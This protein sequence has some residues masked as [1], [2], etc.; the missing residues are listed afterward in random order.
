M[1]SSK[2]QKS[3]LG[4]NQEWS[5]YKSSRVVI[6]PAPYEHTS[7]FGRGTA[8][9]PDQILRAS[10]YLEL[11]D[12]ELDTEIYRLT[13]GI[14]TLPSLSVHDDCRD[15]CVVE[16]IRYEVSRHISQ[17][18]MVVTIGGE[19]TIAIGCATAYTAKFPGLNVLQLDAHS[20]L[21]EEYE[22]NRYSHA[23]VMARICEFNPKIVQLGIRSQSSEEA[24]FIRDKD[25]TT[26]YACKLKTT[27]GGSSLLPWADDVI[28]SL[29][30]HVYITVDCDFFDPSVL[31]AVGTPEPGGFG[32][33][34]TL[35]FLRQLAAERTIVGFDVNELSPIPNLA[36]PE[37]TAAKL[38][39]K[40]IGYIFSSTN[41]ST[42]RSSPSGLRLP[43]RRD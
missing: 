38:I 12:D 40:L 21:R 6:L 7:S 10:A 5:D 17:G 26:F 39:Y 27:G 42:D 22:G 3:F 19:H 1:N 32:W 31:P 41:H 14:S 43:R 16:K 34:E 2:P 20:D 33:D 35:A 11:Y 37:F 18:K 36:Y 28:A 29:G 4:L 24:L 23:S 25:I 15:E 8:L 13:G 30:K 9:G